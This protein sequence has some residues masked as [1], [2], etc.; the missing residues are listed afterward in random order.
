MKMLDQ[1]R[2]GQ[3]KTNMGGQGS[4]EEGRAEGRAGEV[5]KLADEKRA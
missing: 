3:G 2:Q 1:C 4:R 5:L